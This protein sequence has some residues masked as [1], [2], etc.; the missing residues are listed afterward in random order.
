[1]L[2]HLFSHEK[3][4][5]R[6]SDDEDAE[7]LISSSSTSSTRTMNGK[8]LIVMKCLNILRWIRHSSKCSIFR[9]LIILCFILYCLMILRPVKDFQCFYPKEIREKKRFLLVVA[10]PDDECL[11]FNPTLLGLIARNHQGHLIVLSKGNYQGL[12]NLRENEL[13]QSCF[14]LG[15]PS[16]HCLALNISELMDNPHLWWN[17]K[18]IA[19]T[20]DHYLK[21]F[22][23][24]FLITFDSDGI[25][26]HWNHRSIPSA[27]QKFL[28]RNSSQSILIYQLNTYGILFKFSSLFN[29]IPTFLRFLPRFIQNLFSTL[30]PSLISPPSNK[31]LLFVNSP[32][33]FLQGL[34]SFHA[35]QSQLLWFRH[36]YTIFSQYM[37]IN[38]LSLMEFL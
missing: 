16:N 36:L 31:D 23:I 38:H 35:H 29:L 12:G 37:F 32:G 11:F 13:K 26:G 1:M 19:S 15:I 25:S 27:V 28:P 21:Q 14:H 2:L 20:I 24:D 18:I 5:L 9:S 10:H 7:R 17:E 4:S 3:I 30:F 34:R 6:N 33:K 22:Q 8:R